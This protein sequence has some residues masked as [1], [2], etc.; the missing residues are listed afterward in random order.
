[1]RVGEVADA[2]GVTVRTLHHWEHLGLVAPAARHPNG[3]RLYDDGD[4]RRVRTVV[5]WRELGLSLEAVRALLDGGATTEQLEQQLR[6]LEAEAGRI[7]RMTAAVE[8]ALEARRMG[9]ELDPA[10][11]AEVFGD[12]DPT[13]HAAEAQA[14]WGGTDAYAQAHRRTSSYTKDDWVRMRAEQEDLEQRMAAAM[15]AGEPGVALA[16]E[17][18]ALISRW[19]YDCPAEL[20]V[21][22]GEM[23][24]ADERFTAHYDDRAPGLA[25]WLRNAIVTAAR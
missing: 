17:H 5:A 2:T 16:L 22:L 23:Y 25:A 20:H 11:L 4:V 12:D 7:A 21:Q 24:V 19:F 3:Y 13:R 10:E 9:I 15:A 8:R 14:R 6:L 1:M 18:R